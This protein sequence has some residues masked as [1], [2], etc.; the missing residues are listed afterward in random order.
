MDGK[1][2]ENLKR[3]TDKKFNGKKMQRGEK[4]RFRM[5][6]SKWEIY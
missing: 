5:E 2:N 6:E 3:K 1:K 4:M